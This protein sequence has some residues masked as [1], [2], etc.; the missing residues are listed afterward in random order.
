MASL[1]D[2]A[3]Q[4]GSLVEPD[5]LRFDFAHFAALTTEQLTVIEQ[6]VN[7]HEFLMLPPPAPDTPTALRPKLPGPSPCSA[8]STARASSAGTTVLQ[9]AILIREESSAR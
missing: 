2:H 4:Q 1:G 8:R 9:D 7:G 5:R 3:R 6:A